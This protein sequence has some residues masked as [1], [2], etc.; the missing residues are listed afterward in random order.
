MNKYTEETNLAVVKD[1]CSGTAGL[2]VVARRH[3]VDVSSLRKW[4][5]GYRSHG[6]AGVREKERA[7]YSV[8][9]KLSVLRRMRDEGL[10]YRQAAALFDIRN[11]NI[12][13]TWEQNYDQGG[14]DALSP[15]ASLR[16]KKMKKQLIKE[17]PR[18]SQ[19]D[20]RRTREELINELSNLRMENAYLKKLNALAQTTAQQA[21]RKKHKS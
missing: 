11:F 21:Q 16:R 7:A 3:D 13:A 18:Q 17:P 1:Y 6:A 9:F 4:V 14:L 12:I 10:S 5:A 8:K 19:D 2:K 20:D 15:Y